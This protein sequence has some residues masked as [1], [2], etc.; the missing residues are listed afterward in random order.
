ML[1]WKL[2][3]QY[4]PVQKYVLIGAPHTSNWD[5]LF[6]LLLAHGSG[7]QIHWIGKDSLFRPPIGKLMRWL[8]GIPVNR[9]RREN[10]VQQVIE[11]FEGSEKLVIAI[12]PEGT[13]SRV[14]YW[15][16]GFY[17]IA[18]GAGV[19]IALGYIDYGCKELGIGPLIEPT[20]DIQADFKAIQAFYA[21]KTGLHLA[22]HGKI[23]LN[24]E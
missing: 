4:P 11:L 6:A 8:G 1:S 5:L 2:I 12:T 16:T 24:P 15:K 20:G 18:H 19:P 9:S 3:V 14:I 22:K 7:I 10:F 13:R 23:L 21:D 17:H